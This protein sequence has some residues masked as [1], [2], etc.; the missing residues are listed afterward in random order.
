MTNHNRAFHHVP[1]GGYILHLSMLT[2]KHFRC[3]KLSKHVSHV[4]KAVRIHNSSGY[5]IL[6][7]GNILAADAGIPA[8]VFARVASKRC[9]ASC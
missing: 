2:L 1:I 7:Q 6:V 5:T 4:Q 3:F 8:T 9:V